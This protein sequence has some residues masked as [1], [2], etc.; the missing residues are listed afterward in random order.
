MYFF[1]K[2]LAKLPLPTL[3]FIAY[4]I[5]SLLVLFPQQGMRWI[6]RVN[7]WLAYPHLSLDERNQFERKNTY[8]QCLTTVESI[9]CWMPPEYS[10]QQIKKVTGTEILLEALKSPHG[11]IAVVP[12]FGTWEIMNAW[13]NVYTA[14]VIMYKPSKNKGV[15]R[16]MLE[17]RQRLNATLVPT[18]ETGVRAIFKALKRGG[19][20]AILPDQ[21]PD[22][23]GG[24]YSGFF[25]HQVLTSTLVSK[26]AQ[27]TKC[28]VIGLSC[29]RNSS[30][31][32]FE[33]VCE[34]LS[35]EILSSDLQ[36]SVDSLNS[37]IERMISRAPEQ[38]VWA[39][40][41]FKRMQNTNLQNIYDPAVFSL[42]KH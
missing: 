21:V 40:K 38:Y 36:H 42:L 2:F 16:F 22:H 26:L 9:K 1:L 28:R 14:P 15:D 34:N 5:A 41:R 31:D 30:R 3:Q 33:I 8:S 4:C 10:L 13:L 12:H 35:T 37:E 20:T 18:D 23:S 32:G 17:A 11:V 39:Y 19:F 25:G 27:K 29:L 7:T 6:I 24:I